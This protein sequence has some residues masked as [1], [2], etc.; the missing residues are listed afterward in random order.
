MTSSSSNPI[1]FWTQPLSI[2][3]KI[4]LLAEHMAFESDKKQHSEAIVQH[5]GALF[6]Q[7]SIEYPAQAIRFAQLLTQT[8]ESTQTPKG[9]LAGLCYLG[10]CIAEHESIPFNTVCH[11]TG[12][13]HVSR[14][15]RSSTREWQFPNEQIQ[16]ASTWFFDDFIEVLSIDDREDHGLELPLS[17]QDNE[18]EE[19]SEQD[20]DLDDRF[21]SRPLVDGAQLLQYY[22]T[23]WHFYYYPEDDSTILMDIHQCLL[24]A[25]EPELLQQAIHETA[26]EH[27]TYSD[28]EKGLA[29]PHTAKPRL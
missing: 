24:A 18:E 12:D 21:T 26:H 16:E 8:P 14:A 9:P 28:L 29:A 3:Q 23:D 25:T 15:S 4:T 13:E 11:R 17:D 20:G 2:S 27:T 10:A 1:P 6:L 22:I 5:A 19:G 7:W